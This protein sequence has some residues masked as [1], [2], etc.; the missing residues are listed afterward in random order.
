MHCKDIPNTK[1][2]SRHV[3]KMVRCK[4]G[5]GGVKKALGTGDF[6]HYKLAVLKLK[7]CL[8]VL[9]VNKQSLGA[10]QYAFKNTTQ[11]YHFIFRI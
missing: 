4:G 10:L 6:G 9:L 7:N 2:N 1:Q 3:S 8:A 5:G 11:V